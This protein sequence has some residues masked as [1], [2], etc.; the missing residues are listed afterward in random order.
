MQWNAAFHTAEECGGDDRAHEALTEDVF[1][2]YDG[3]EKWSW[4]DSIAFG[5]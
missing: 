2:E 5:T 1:S 4:W 3:A